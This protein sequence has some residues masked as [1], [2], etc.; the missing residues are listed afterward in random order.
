MRKEGRK[1]YLGVGEFGSLKKNVGETLVNSVVE[2]L[3]LNQDASCLELVGS[4]LKTSIVSKGVH[5]LEKNTRMS[6]R[7][8]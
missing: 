7:R 3:A 6:K 4:G 8:G 1:A 5:G 2:V